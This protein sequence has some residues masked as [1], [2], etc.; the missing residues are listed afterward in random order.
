MKM[1]NGNSQVN[2]K[3][4]KAELKKNRTRKSWNNHCS[5]KLSACSP[6]KLKQIVIGPYIFYLNY[7]PRSS[8]S[9]LENMNLGRV[10]ERGIRLECKIL[11]I[12]NNLSHGLQE[13]S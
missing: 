9:D 1:V 6:L 7:I 10:R 13:W 4:N 11:G 12:L 8:I 2:I 5:G 3:K